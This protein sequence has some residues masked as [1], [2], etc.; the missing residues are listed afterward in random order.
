M[1]LG[2]CKK[3][4]V[5][6]RLR[7]RPDMAKSVATRREENDDNGP[8]TKGG[9]LWKRDEKPKG[10]SWFM[11]QKYYMSSNVVKWINVKPYPTAQH[12]DDAMTEKTAEKKVPYHACGELNIFNRSQ[13]ATKHFARCSGSGRHGRARRARG[14]VADAGAAIL[15]DDDGA[16]VGARGAGRK[17]PVPPTLAARHSPRY[18]RGRSP[19]LPPDQLLPTVGRKSCVS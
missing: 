12:D 13:T 2:N 11:E 17:Q 10:D 1:S 6:K 7:I 4:V 3:I 14:R 19:P 18:Q 9:W 15:R 16:R 5:W 8:I